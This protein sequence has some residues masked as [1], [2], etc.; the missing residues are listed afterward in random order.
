MQTEY[1]PGRSASPVQL[2][3][4]I[5]LSSLLVAGIGSVAAGIWLNTWWTIAGG[6]AALAG[7]AWL[8]TEPR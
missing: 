6:V 8:V 4:T 1:A 7:A 3:R 2:S 5:L